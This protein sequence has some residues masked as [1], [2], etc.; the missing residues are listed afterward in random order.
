M[1]LFDATVQFQMKIQKWSK[2]SC[3]GSRSS[4]YEHACM[5]FHVVVWQRKT[6][7]LRIKLL[8]S[9]VSFFGLL[10]LSSIS[11]RSSTKELFRQTVIDNTQHPK[12][13]IR[14][15]HLERIRILT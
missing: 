7:V 4:K 3:G 15:S 10:K 14:Q 8:F 2:I 6:T 12:G 9:D 5:S 1:P 11:A 13:L